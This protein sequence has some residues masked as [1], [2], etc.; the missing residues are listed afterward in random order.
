MQVTN[1]VD[2][3]PCWFEMTSSDPARSFAFYQGL[4]GW[5]KVD[6]D[7]GEMGVYSFLRNGNGSVGGHCALP[8]GDPGPSRWNVYFQ[9]ASADAA[10]ARVAEL[11]GKV[12]MPP[13]DVP[14]N[15]RMLVA[16]DPT[17]AYFS[18]W[19]PLSSG[20]DMVMFEDHAIG[21]VELATRDVPAAQAFYTALLGWQCERSTGSAMPEGVTYIE[22][23]VGGTRYGGM[24]QMTPEWG[25]IPPHWGVYVLVPDVDATVAR[26]LS[27]GGAN[28]VPAFDA[29][30]VGRIAL[31]SEPTG[32]HCYVIRL[33]R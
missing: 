25:E 10:A 19:Q 6:S 2:G 28:P 9:V 21:W 12:V 33:A 31:V 22:Y 17:G 3:Q 15:G 14:G 23:A 8:P 1:P 24:L 18:L 32:A 27:L 4:F 13:F 7:M 26:A 29:P 16:S 5:A 20:G 11:G 30:G